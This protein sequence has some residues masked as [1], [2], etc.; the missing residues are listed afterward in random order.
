[1]KKT[2]FKPGD[3]V[4]CI[5]TK[6]LSDGALELQKEYVIKTSE[7]TVYGYDMLFIEGVSD[8]KGRFFST[9]FELVESSSNVPTTINIAELNEKNSKG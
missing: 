7:N 9:R 4:R 5:D 1:M 8:L 2:E 3:K 6:G